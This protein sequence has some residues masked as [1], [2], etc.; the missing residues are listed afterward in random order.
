MDSSFAGLGAGRGWRWSGPLHRLSM[1]H[2]ADRRRR[3]SRFP[4]AKTPELELSSSTQSLCC[5]ASG[6]AAAA[7]ALDRVA[8]MIK[9]AV[10]RSSGRRVR[11]EDDKI[12]ATKTVAPDLPLDVLRNMDIRVDP[13][14][15]PPCAPPNALRIRPAHARTRGV[16]VSRSYF[17]S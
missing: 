13:W 2:D 6:A 10:Y 4:E 12:P 15:A 5:T 14:S 17:P 3:G 1:R 11:G 8:G 16:H 9:K 7:D